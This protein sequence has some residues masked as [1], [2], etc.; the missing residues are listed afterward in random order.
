VGLGE[1]PTHRKGHSAQFGDAHLEILGQL[2]GRQRGEAGRV[3]L[4]RPQG[5][6]WQTAFENPMTG[7]SSIPFGA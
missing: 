6:V 5:P 3:L 4:V 1:A 2:V 7:W